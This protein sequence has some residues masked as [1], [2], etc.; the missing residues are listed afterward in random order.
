MQIVSHIPVMRIWILIGTTV[1]FFP[2]P[3]FPRGRIRPAHF[4]PGEE[5][6]QSFFSPR[7]KNNLSVF[8]PP[9]QFFPHLKFFNISYI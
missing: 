7:E 1:S 6:D 9:S 8:S 3:V 4:F 5:T 2:P